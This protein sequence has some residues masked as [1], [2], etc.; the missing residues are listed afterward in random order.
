MDLLPGKTLGE[1]SAHVGSHLIDRLESAEDHPLAGH[2]FC[3]YA[4]GYMGAATLLFLAWRSMSFHR[5]PGNQSSLRPL[6]QFIA[7]VGYRNIG[8]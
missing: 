5:M 4:A 1:S 2:G 8:L 3:S 6:L 7:A